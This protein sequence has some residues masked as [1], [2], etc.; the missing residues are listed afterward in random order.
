[1]Q[2]PAVENQRE[3]RMANHSTTTELT[4]CSTGCAGHTN[5]REVCSEYGAFIE[6]TMAEIA[7]MEPSYAALALS[8]P[9]DSSTVSLESHE[10]PF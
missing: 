7:A 4:H 9:S 6:Y 8:T 1:M 10:I 3:N 5:A 2:Q